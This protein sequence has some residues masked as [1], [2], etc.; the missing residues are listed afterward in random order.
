MQVFVGIPLEM[1]H[2]PIRVGSLYLTGVIAASLTV[3]VICNPSDPSS[4]AGASGGVYCLIAA[5]LSTLILNW[6]D[7]KY[8]I[9]QRVRLGKIAH[10]TK[11]GEVLRIFKLFLIIVYTVGDMVQT[12]LTK[13]SSTSWVAHVAGATA[14]LLIAIVVLK[15]RR[16]EEWE[17]WLKVTCLVVFSIA[18]IVLFVLN[19]C[20]T[21]LVEGSENEEAANCASWRL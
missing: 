2:G 16:V 8:I 14:G 7:D 3:S 20:I 10:A 11:N 17:T 9:V 4:L 12:I 6:N 15:N 21:C 1:T 19:F 13:D 5:H 18:L